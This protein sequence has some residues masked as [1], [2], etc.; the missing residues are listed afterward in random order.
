[1][2]A[3]SD[4]FASPGSAP[5]G[6]AAQQH[7]PERRR[8]SRATLALGLVVTSVVAAGAGVGAFLGIRTM[9]SSTFEKCG[10]YQCFRNVDQSMIEKNA[11]AHGFT[12]NKEVLSRT[13]TLQSTHRNYKITFE[14]MRS[15]LSAVS[16]DVTVMDGFTADTSAN[17]FLLWVTE[18]VY[19]GSQKN[20]SDIT[21]WLQTRI[22]DTRPSTAEIDG[23]RF[24]FTIPGDNNWQLRIK[25]A[26]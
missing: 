3:V 15:G 19:T 10:V 17:N 12:C 7:P 14:R 9:Q 18:Q 11:A 22:R 6:D 23:Y 25:V 13:C 26:S 20:Q 24:A 1:M 4:P 21:A 2:S 8:K 5:F 16:A